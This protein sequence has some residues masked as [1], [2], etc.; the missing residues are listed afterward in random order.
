MNNELNPN[1]IFLLYA[2]LKTKGKSRC[3]GERHFLMKFSVV[4]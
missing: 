4:N 2:P 1:E 3:F